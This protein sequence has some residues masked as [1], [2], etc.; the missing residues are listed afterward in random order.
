VR[1]A[2]GRAKIEE[3]RAYQ[4]Q[5]AVDEIA[6]NV[7]LYD[8]TDACEGAVISPNACEIRTRHD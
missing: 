1:E 2:A 3:S 5:L 4:L 8:Y 7:I 6:I